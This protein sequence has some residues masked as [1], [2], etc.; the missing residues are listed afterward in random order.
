MTLAEVTDWA[1]GKMVE[2][3][4]AHKPPFHKDN[5]ATIDRA[6]VREWLDKLTALEAQQGAVRRALWAAA[7][8]P[9][10]SSWYESEWR[11]VG[12]CKGYPEVRFTQTGMRVMGKFY[13]WIY[14]GREI[15]KMGVSRSHAAVE[16]WSKWAYKRHTRL[17]YCDSAENRASIIEE[18]KSMTQE[19]WEKYNA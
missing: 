3:H 19:E 4:Y 6:D 11:G 7:G 5:P 10:R 15:L 2:R 13:W 17:S 16:R 14:R 8:L 12:M 18:E 9:K 1:S